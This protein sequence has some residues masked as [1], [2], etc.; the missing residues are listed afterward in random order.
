MGHLLEAAEIFEFAGREFSSGE[1]EDG[2]KEA[3]SQP[4]RVTVEAALNRM[5]FSKLSKVFRLQPALACPEGSSLASMR[6]KVQTLEKETSAFASG[7]QSVKTAQEAW[8]SWLSSP[9]APSKDGLSQVSAEGGAEAAEGEGS[10]GLEEKLQKV[11]RWRDRET[12]AVVSQVRRLLLSAHGEASKSDAVSAERLLPLDFLS[13]AAALTRGALF[14]ASPL[15]AVK[16]LGRVVAESHG[17]P[18]S[19]DAACGRES[20]EWKEAAAS[21]VRAP[22]ACDSVAREE[23]SRL[24]EG[25]PCA[26]ETFGCWGWQMLGCCVFFGDFPAPPAAGRPTTAAREAFKRVIRRK[27][28]KKQIELTSL[29]R[30]F[31]LLSGAALHFAGMERTGLGHS[32]LAPLEDTA[33]RLASEASGSSDSSFTFWSFTSLSFPLRAL[34][35]PSSNSPPEVYNTA[36]LALRRRSVP[37]QTA[38]SG[39]QVENLC[40]SSETEASERKRPLTRE[41]SNGEASTPSKKQK[42][43]EQSSSQGLES[44]GRATEFQSG[45]EGE[46]PSTQLATDDNDLS[47]ELLWKNFENSLTAL[48]AGAVASAVACDCVCGKCV[49][50][51][52]RKATATNPAFEQRGEARR[53]GGPSAAPPSE[54]S[55]V[56]ER[57]TQKVEAAFLHC[58][59]AGAAAA[60][61]LLLPTTCVPKKVRKQLAKSLQREHEA[62]AAPALS[63]GLVSVQGMKPAQRSSFFHRVLAAF[64]Q[65]CGRGKEGLDLGAEGAQGESAGGTEEATPEAGCTDSVV[66]WSEREKLYWKVSCSLCSNTGLPVA[67]RRHLQSIHSAV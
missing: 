62:D 28:N 11:R 18:E 52:F 49:S 45:S 2:L 34:K 44:E 48:A 66:K 30:A 59:F 36:F 3:P 65:Q 5:R 31:G 63:K 9:E 1:E 19:E 40:N 6:K 10:P 24:A 15:E 46:S 51:P 42:S 39:D 61:D 50:K 38:P 21:L 4:L 29:K 35:P 58:L 26:C 16:R 33:R 43:G 14:E 17:E 12:A 57:E 55:C 23:E 7:G 53:Q 60:A 47:E 20:A 27:G 22:F 56:F 25:V 37:P 8:Q 64:S 54:Q 41:T 32:D 13:A 67:L